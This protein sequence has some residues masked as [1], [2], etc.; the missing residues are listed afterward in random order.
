MPRGWT[1]D[2][3]SAWS[4]LGTEDTGWQD[5]EAP[6]LLGETSLT[7][8]AFLPTLP[9]LSEVVPAS[10]PLAPAGGQVDHPLAPASRPRLGLPVIHGRSN[11][12]REG[13]ADLGPALAQDAGPPA[14]TP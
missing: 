7:T 8:H 5:R 12:S 9:G 6:G 4:P 1:T 3:S 10:A 13:T 2:R 14:F 11:S